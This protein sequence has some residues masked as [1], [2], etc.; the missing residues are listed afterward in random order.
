[1][2]EKSG[3]ALLIAEGVSNSDETEEREVGQR[4]I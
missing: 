3:S 2:K 1:M 4:S